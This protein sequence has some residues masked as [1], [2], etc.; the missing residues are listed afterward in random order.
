MGTVC[1]LI[2]PLLPFPRSLTC[3]ENLLEWSEVEQH[4]EWPFSLSFSFFCVLLFP[5]LLVPGEIQ[6]SD[7]PSLSSLKGAE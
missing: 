6:A 1:S 5:L 3:V 2:S 4:V 7:N